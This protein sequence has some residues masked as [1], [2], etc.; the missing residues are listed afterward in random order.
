[1]SYAGIVGFPAKPWKHVEAWL[2]RATQRP[3]FAVSMQP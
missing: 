3:G 2:G 1:V